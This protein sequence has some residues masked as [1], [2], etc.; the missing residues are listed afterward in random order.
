MLS[1]VL[2]TD[3][4]N[5][6]KYHLVTVKPSFTVKMIDCLHETGPTAKNGKV[7]YVIHML[8]DYRHVGRCVQN[9]SYS[10]PNWEWN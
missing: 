6:L 10:S 4:Q 3:T 5:T 7:R 9:G 8:H 2:S 1:A